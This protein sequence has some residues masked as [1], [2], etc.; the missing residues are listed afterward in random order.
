MAV[1]ASLVHAESVEPVGTFTV[2]IGPV[3]WEPG[4]GPAPGD[5]VLL[6]VVRPP[7]GSVLAGP[8]GWVALE[9]ARSFWKVF[10]PREPQTVTFHARYAEVWEVRGWVVAAGSYELPVVTP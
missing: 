5:L 4:P 3:F 9:D 2:D 8:P 10:G 7:P 1:T 6:S